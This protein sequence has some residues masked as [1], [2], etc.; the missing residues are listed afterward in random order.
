MRKLDNWLESFVEYGSA[1]EAPF[2][3]LFWVGVATVAGALERKCWFDQTTFKWFPNMF[4]VL[5]APPGI[6]SKTTTSDMGK[7]IFREIDELSLGPN[8]VT[9][10]AL[11]K[12]MKRAAS[13]TEYEK[14]KWVDTSSLTVFAGELGNLLKVNDRDMMDMLVTLWDCGFI[15][16]ETVK[17][18]METI[19]YPFLNLVGCTTPGW[20]SENIPTY[21][22][23]GGLVSRIVWVYGGEEKRQFVAYPGFQDAKKTKD[24]LLLKQQL[25]EDL[26]D[27]STLKG[28]FTLSPEARE[29]GEKWYK[30][31][32][33]EH[34]GKKDDRRFGGYFARKQTHIHKLAMVLSAVRGDSLIIEL[35]DLQRAEKEVTALESTMSHVFD[36]IGKTEA[37][38]NA[39][40][41]LDALGRSPE[42]LTL[43][44]LYRVVKTYFPRFD[45]Y[46]SI[47][48]GL[49]RSGLVKTV[50]EKGQTIL[51]TSQC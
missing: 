42:G 14:G 2:S 6:I 21:M 33:T 31:H 20:I 15:Q 45:D 44:G 10:P 3:T 9:W 1:G 40:R 19:E 34:G 22:I 16:K 36:R 51:R 41:V 27:I 4:V 11:L 47:L 5:V 13:A 48:K 38:T 12:A 49:T 29:W 7:D 26:R 28:A 18:G 8:V 39:D 50:Q 35:E 23:E 32:W 17:D 46:L 30:E 25:L 24:R 43:E 37:S